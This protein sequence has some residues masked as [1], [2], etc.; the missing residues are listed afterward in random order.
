MRELINLNLINNFDL[1]QS[2]LSKLEENDLIPHPEPK[3]SSL[4]FVP[5]NYF[6]IKSLDGENFFY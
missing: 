2:F 6:I 5:K 1:P 4:I 3:L